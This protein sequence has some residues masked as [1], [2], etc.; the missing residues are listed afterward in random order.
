MKRQRAI[1]KRQLSRL[2]SRDTPWLNPQQTELIVELMFETIAMGVIRDGW[3][4]IRGFGK[5]FSRRKKVPPK[6]PSGVFPRGMTCAKA[7]QRGLARPPTAITKGQPR[8]VRE[9]IYFRP[10]RKLNKAVES[11][12]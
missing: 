5:F 7:V 11:R 4:E 10:D 12:R 8:Q 3:C 2:V 9:V 6:R 1:D